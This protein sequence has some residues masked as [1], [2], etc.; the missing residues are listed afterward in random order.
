MA[1]RNPLFEKLP[2]DFSRQLQLQLNRKLLTLNSINH[3]R[4][5]QNVMFGDGHVKFQ[6]TRFIDIS[7][8]DIFTLQDTDIYQGCE[9]PSCETDSF[10]AP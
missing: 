3:N 9:V 5:G 4:R 2:V 1:D 8:D 6:K 10:L 7:D